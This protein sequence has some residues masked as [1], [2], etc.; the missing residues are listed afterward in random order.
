MGQY[1]HAV[2]LLDTGGNANGV[3]AGAAAGAVGDAPKVRAQ[4]GDVRGGLGYRVIGVAGL[5]GENLK[6]QRGAVRF[7]M[8]IIFM[9]ATPL[10]GELGNIISQMGEKSYRLP[11]RKGQLFDS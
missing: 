7:K 1:I 2:L 9:E 5:G 8:S 11:K 10:L 3:V 6:G 4:G